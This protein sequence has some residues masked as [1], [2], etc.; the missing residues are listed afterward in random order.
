MYEPRA[1][2][3]VAG[4]LVVMGVVVG[5]LRLQ[6]VLDHVGKLLGE[7]DG[8]KHREEQY[9]REHAHVATVTDG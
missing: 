4:P 7:L 5:R 6:H 9:D 8:R 2:V 3:L 1:A